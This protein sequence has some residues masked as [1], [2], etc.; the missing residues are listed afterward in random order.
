MIEHLLWEVNTESSINTAPAAAKFG[1]RM[2]GGDKLAFHGG[3]YLCYNSCVKKILK[4]AVL[5]IAPL[6]LFGGIAAAVDG[7]E[8]TGFSLSQNATEMTSKTDTESGFFWAAQGGAPVYGI[9]TVRN[10]GD[11]DFDLTT[12][13]TMTAF[14]GG[15]EIAV[16]AGQTRTVV[17]GETI[18]AV[19][20]LGCADGEN[21]CADIPWIGLFWATGS[22]TFSGKTYESR[23]LLLILPWQVVVIVIAAVLIIIAALLAEK[24]KNRKNSKRKKNS[25]TSV[26]KNLKKLEDKETAGT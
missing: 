26:R 4:I 10:T 21:D 2:W 7:G 15:G 25:G 11:A 13:L 24:R 12:R 6:F 23:R 5:I 16:S 1:G 18:R 20:K 22:A 9:T 14:H 19:D 17:P 3:T 8:I